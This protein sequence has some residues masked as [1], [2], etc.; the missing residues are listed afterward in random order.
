MRRSIVG[1]QGPLGRAV[2]LALVF[3]LPDMGRRWVAMVCGVLAE[4]ATGLWA[5]SILHEQAGAS[6]SSAASL[7]IG[8]FIGMAAGRLSLSNVLRRFAPRRILAFSFS[9]AIVACVPFLLGACSDVV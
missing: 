5:A 2:G 8:F 7:T 6:K 9:G 3:R 1:T 4:I